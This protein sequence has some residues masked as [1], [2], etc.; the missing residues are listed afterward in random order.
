MCTGC[1]FQ[2]T[3]GSEVGCDQPWG[4]CG[5]VC[6]HRRACRRARQ[7]TAT[8]PGAAARSARGALPGR[9]VNRRGGSSM[10]ASPSTPAG[11][12]AVGADLERG[13]RPLPESASPTCLVR[14]HLRH[15][16]AELTVVD[17]R[18]GPR[19]DQR[20]QP[21]RVVR[22]HDHG[23]PT[24]AGCRRGPCTP[25]RD[26]RVSA[27]LKSGIVSS[28]VRILASRYPDRWTASA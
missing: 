15:G 25:A 18:S 24:A 10:S 13:R 2:R 3:F 4:R 6:G 22:H 7:R 5:T 17:A 20:A 23:G 28:T 19:S 16:D 8:R 9:I 27:A 12:G 1:T 26:R 14:G 11:T 21:I